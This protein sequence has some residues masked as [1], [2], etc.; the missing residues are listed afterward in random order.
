MEEEEQAVQ[1]VLIRDLKE[2]VG[3][4]QVSEVKVVLEIFSTWANQM[5]RSTV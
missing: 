1:K 4:V 5:C 3:Q 2:V